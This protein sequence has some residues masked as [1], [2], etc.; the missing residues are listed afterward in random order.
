MY[1]AVN[2][3]PFM[4]ILMASF[5][6]I[7]NGNKDPHS[8]SIFGYQFTLNGTA[9]EVDDLAAKKLFNNGHFKPANDRQNQ[10]KDDLIATAAKFGVTLDKRKTFENLQKQVQELI[11]GDQNAG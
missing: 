10:A 1:G 3:R 2:S 8:T 7:G 9:V 4:E 11:D 6:F 5:V